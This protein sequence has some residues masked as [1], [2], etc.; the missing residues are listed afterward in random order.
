MML[1]C[2]AVHVGSMM[3]SCLLC[4]VASCPNLLSGH[5]GCCCSV[6]VL[7][8]QRAGGTLCFVWNIIMAQVC[9]GMLGGWSEGVN[10]DSPDAG[11]SRRMH[12]PCCLPSSPS[13]FWECGSPLTPHT[14]HSGWLCGILLYWAV[15]DTRNIGSYCLYCPLLHC[16]QVRIYIYISAVH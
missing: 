7:A 2:L 12:P 5:S 1:S 9:E 13:V 3:L 6:E 15:W 4:C 14:L 11:T 16:M 8:V 10:S